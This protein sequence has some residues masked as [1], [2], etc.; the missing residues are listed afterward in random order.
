MGGASSAIKRRLRIDSAG[1]AGGATT[2]LPPPSAGTWQLTLT[3]IVIEFIL[4]AV[5][6]HPLAAYVCPKNNEALFVAS[7]SIPVTP[8][9][10]FAG[11]A[12]SLVSSSLSFCSPHSPVAISANCP[13]A[14]NLHTAFSLGEE[15]EEEEGGG[16]MAWVQST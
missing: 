16:A 6:P 2:P 1:G 3:L 13:N 5:L 14:A 7:I 11:S 9:P 4:I 12:S 15:E 10:S 8:P